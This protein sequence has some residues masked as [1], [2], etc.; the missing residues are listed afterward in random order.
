MA[1]SRIGGH[2]GSITVIDGGVFVAH[3]DFAVEHL[4]VFEDVVDHLLVEILGRDLEADLHAAGFFGLEV[5]V[6]VTALAIITFYQ[7]KNIEQ[8]GVLELTGAHGSVESLPLP[9][10]PRATASAPPS[11][12]HPESCR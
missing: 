5:D 11:S 6:A 2:W 10:R 9:A 1:W 8:R 3:Q 12:S 7:C 4:V